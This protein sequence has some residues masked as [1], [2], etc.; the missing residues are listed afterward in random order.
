[1]YVYRYIV[2]YVYVGSDIPRA[3]SRYP[4]RFQ[5]REFYLYAYA[6]TQI[7]ADTFMYG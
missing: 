4:D 5:H 7:Y 3:P 6:Y 1:M 2:T